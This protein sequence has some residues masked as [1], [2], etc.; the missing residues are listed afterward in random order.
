MPIGG[1]CLRHTHQVSQGETRNPTT[2]K[3][4]QGALC[5]RATMQNIYI[6]QLVWLVLT[7]NTRDGIGVIGDP[8][9]VRA[10]EFNKN[11]TFNSF[12]VVLD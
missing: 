1:R 10:Y 12:R 4:R 6:R 3:V 9:L 8:E 5:Q 7:Q 2:Q 11:C